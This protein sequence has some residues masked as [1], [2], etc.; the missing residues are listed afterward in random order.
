MC[1]VGE[2]VEED[3]GVGCAV[4]RLQV[5]VSAALNCM[6]HIANRPKADGRSRFVAIVTKS[7]IGDGRE[8]HNYPTATGR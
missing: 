1:R 8:S 2:A 5:V 7:L 6:R 3:L 4:V